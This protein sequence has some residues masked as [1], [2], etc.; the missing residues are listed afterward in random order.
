MKGV[1]GCQTSS[2]KKENYNSLY[3]FTFFLAVASYGPPPT[4][5]NP[6]HS[7][8]HPFHVSL[9]PQMVIPADLPERRTA[10]TGHNLTM[11]LTILGIVLLHLLLLGK[12]GFAVEI[13]KGMYHIAVARWL[14]STIEPEMMPHLSISAVY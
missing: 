1:K 3:F 10:L 9:T 13:V 5:H 12:K 7:F 8:L 2:R 6:S 4:L 14:L 11:S